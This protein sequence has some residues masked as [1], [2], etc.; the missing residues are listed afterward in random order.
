[1]PP[2]PLVASTLC[3]EFLK[4]TVAISMLWLGIDYDLAMTLSTAAA[5][6]QYLRKLSMVNFHYTNH[7]SVNVG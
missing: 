2:T 3:T 7:T 1:M 6:Q 5:A 4:H